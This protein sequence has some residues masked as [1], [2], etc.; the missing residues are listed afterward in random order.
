MSNSNPTSPSLRPNFRAVLR[1]AVTLTVLTGCIAFADAQTAAAIQVP[2]LDT[3]AA[4]L[5]SSS[6]DQAAT[7]D[8]TTTVASLNPAGGV[9]FAN[10][11]QYGGGQRRRY[12]QPRYRGSNTNADGSPKYSFFAGAGLAQPIGNTWHYLT[13]SYGFQVGGGRNFNAK[14]GL[15]LQFDYDH[16]GFTGQTLS[17]Q[18]YLYFDD[19]TPADNGLDGSSHIWSFTLNPVYNLVSGDKGGVGAYLVAGT[20]FYHKVANF[21]TPQVQCLDIYCFYQGY[22]NATFQHY[23][24]NAPGFSG[25]F[26]LTYKFS[27]F[28]NERFYMEARYVFMDNSQRQ[29]YTVKNSSYSTGG[30]FT[31]TYNGNDVYPANSNRTTYIPIKVGLR[32]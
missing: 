24:S 25:G 13:P 4:P 30:V 12:G 29:G 15:M 23:T 7:P 17:N 16:F 19:S 14:L 31:S 5:F 10:Y 32:F 28:S 9:N 6:S 20:G 27:R 21:T 11:M 3:S 22:V 1:A 2:A 8:G 26:G 18:S